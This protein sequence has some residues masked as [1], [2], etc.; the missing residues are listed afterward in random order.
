LPRA[1]PD[2]PTARARSFDHAL[3]VGLQ[4]PAE[5]TLPLLSLAQRLA[6]IAIAGALLFER[7]LDRAVPIKRRGLRDR[8]ADP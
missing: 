3:T 7:L 6:G 5:L 1:R 8:S 2:D 4:I